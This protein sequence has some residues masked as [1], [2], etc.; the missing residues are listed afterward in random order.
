MRKS[1]RGDPTPFTHQVLMHHDDLSGR[2]AKADNPA[3]ANIKMPQPVWG[4]AG[5]GNAVSAMM[6][7]EREIEVLVLELNTRRHQHA[8]TATTGSMLPPQA[9]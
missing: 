2:T 3:S 7:L 1:V 9:G 8:L 4:C 5:L 6:F